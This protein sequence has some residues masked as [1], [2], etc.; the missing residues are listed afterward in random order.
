MTTHALSRRSDLRRSAPARKL[1]H[2][3]AGVGVDGLRHRANAAA[4]W[5]LPTGSTSGPSS[6]AKKQ[7]RLFALKDGS[8]FALARIW[9]YWKDKETGEALESFAI[10]TTDP[11]DW[12][13]M[14]HDRMAVN[15]KPN[16]YQR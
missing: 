4:V 5:F 10:V 1:S 14:Y 8:P 16:N 12:M 13:A 9:D 7:A 6:M 11:S 3:Q 2:L 15:L